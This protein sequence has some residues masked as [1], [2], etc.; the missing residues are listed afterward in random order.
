MVAGSGGVISGRRLDQPGQCYA[1]RVVE[2]GVGEA[3]LQHLQARGNALKEDAALLERHA[4]GGVPD[5]P[6]LRIGQRE[7]AAMVWRGW[8]MSTAIPRSSR[9]YRRQ[10]RA[11]GRPRHPCAG[12]AEK[13]TS[14]G[15]TPRVPIAVVVALP[16]EHFMFVMFGF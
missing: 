14:L 7:H 3:P 12:S 10:T 5:G 13:E 1:H 15:I 11:A 6:K 9:K 2:V 16:G 4:V 8:R